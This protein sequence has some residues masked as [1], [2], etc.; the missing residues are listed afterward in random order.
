MFNLFKRPI[1]IILKEKKVSWTISDSHIAR[2]FFQSQTGEKILAILEDATISEK[3]KISPS[4]IPTE[5][6]YSAGKADGMAILISKIKS[7]QPVPEDGESEDKDGSGDPN[8][9][10]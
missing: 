9:D 10:L 5:I 1:I 8:A 2:D 3:N 6:S 7:L 4:S